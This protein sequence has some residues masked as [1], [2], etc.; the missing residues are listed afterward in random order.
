VVVVWV[1]ADADATDPKDPEPKSIPRMNAFRPHVLAAFLQLAPLTRV[2]QHASPKL[3]AGPA[4]AILRWIFGTASVAGSMHG[5]SGASGISPTTV[6]ATNGIRS[7][8]TFIVSDTSHGT[9]AAYSTTS[10]LPPGLALS[11]RGILSGTPTNGGSYTLSIRGWENANFSGNSATKNVTVTVVNT[12]PP[13]ITTPPTNVTA[14]PGQ[15]ATFA[16]EFTGHRP[17]TLRWFKEDIE[18]SGATNATL[19][20]T[21]VQPSAAG[22]YRV[23][24][25]NSVATVFS[26]FVNLAVATPNPPPSITAQPASRSVHAGETVRLGVG[27]A[28]DGLSFAWTRGSQAVG[29]NSSE[30]VLTNVTEGDGGTYAVRITN[31]GGATNSVSALLTVVPPLRLDPPGRSAD[32]VLL[33]FTGIEGRP[34]RLESAGDLTGTFS[35]VLDVLGRST[36]AVMTLAPTNAVRVFRV[37]TAN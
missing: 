13:V 10:P 4:I 12:A 32:S 15:N 21:N 26:E 20:L 6:R 2:F 34:Y 25:V 16:V 33:R 18:V 36:G 19:T 1:A 23:R 14:N 5:L 29:G 28:G 24:L 27:A 8:T 3:A 31:A 9:A 30:L 35:P 17:L 7:S 22:R 11:N 37:R